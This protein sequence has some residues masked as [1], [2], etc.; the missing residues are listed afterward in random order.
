MPKIYVKVGKRI[1]GWNVDAALVDIFM[2]MEI[3]TNKRVKEVIGSIDYVLE[4]QGG[5]CWD[6]LVDDRRVGWVVWT[7]LTE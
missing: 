6:I 1:K 4:Y 3:Q 5:W 2:E 7:H